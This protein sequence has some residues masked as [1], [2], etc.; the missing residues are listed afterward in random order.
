M[1]AV[2]EILNQSAVRTDPALCLAKE[3]EGVFNMEKEQA[4]VDQMTSQAFG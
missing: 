4:I 3:K 1:K 2:G